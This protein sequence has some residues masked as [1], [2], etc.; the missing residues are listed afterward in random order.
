V[1]ERRIGERFGRMNLFF[2]APRALTLFRRWC[3]M[4]AKR[5]ET[6]ETEDE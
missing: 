1:A 2:H 6:S 3:K 4:T 5:G